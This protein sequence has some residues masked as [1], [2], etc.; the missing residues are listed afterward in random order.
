MGTMTGGIRAREWPTLDAALLAAAL[1]IY[2]F[3]VPLGLARVEVAPQVAAGVALDTSAESAIYAVLGM[4][5][6]AWVPLGDLTMRANLASVVLGALATMLFGRLCLQVLLLLRP[7]AHARQEPRAFLYEPIAASAAALA[8]AL[9]LST[10]AVSTTAGNAAA[11]LLILA[12][13]LLVG[14]A[15]L[16]DW[17][18]AT[19]GSALAGLAGLSS[20]VAPIA[21]PLLWPLLVGAGVW[22]LRKGA[23][24]PL[25]APVVFVAGWG[26]SALA[27][28]AASRSPATLAG[29]L[30]GLRQL[31]VHP[32]AALA[33]TALELADQL[34]VVGSLLAAIGVVVVAARAA[35]PAAWLLLTLVSAL[36]F[37]RPSDVQATGPDQ[38][39][40]PAALA[41]AA[42]FAAA[43][44]VHLSSRL[45]RARLAA[46]A[47]LA[48]MLVLTPAMDGGT[49]RW[50]RR[51]A[52][53]MRLLDHALARADL[54]SQVDPGTPAM[55]GLFRLAK[56]IGL[57]PDLVLSRPAARP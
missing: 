37:A 36:L 35:V 10:F 44:L 25:L 45:G 19:A 16:R 41:V 30:R 40:L 13:G 55:A 24:W 49:A 34:G 54:R 57:R 50:L 47:T 38:A 1:A 6:A 2:A 46:A 3:A 7:S 11:T 43:G 32:G 9:S 12:A 33:A 4:R 48:V 39:A 31:G 8:L 52:L 21:G 29:L 23:R 22:A 14:L 28:V 42:V 27:V 20:G 56:V 53:P 5:L 15:L 26:G 17:T 18:S 51:P